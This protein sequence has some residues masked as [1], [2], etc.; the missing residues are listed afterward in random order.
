MRLL[1]SIYRTLH[2]IF[3]FQILI[4]EDSFLFNALVTHFSFSQQVTTSPWAEPWAAASSR[5]RRGRRNTP[6][7]TTPTTPPNT[8]PSLRLSLLR[9]GSSFWGTSTMTWCSTACS[10]RA[11]CS[12]RWSLGPWKAVACRTLFSSEIKWKPTVFSPT[13]VS[14]CFSNKHFWLIYIIWIEFSLLLLN[15]HLLYFVVWFCVC[16]D[17]CDVSFV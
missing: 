14:K 4:F 17:S 6:G 1:Q 8:T 7:E 5:R 10:P 2:L 12:T 16:R 3:F 11:T 13:Y 15:Y 9:D